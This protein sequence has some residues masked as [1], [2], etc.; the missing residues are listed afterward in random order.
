MPNRNAMGPMGY[1]PMTGR[2][3]GNCRVLENI[4]AASFGGINL[5]FC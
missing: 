4:N 2:R 1:G 3:M 5:Y